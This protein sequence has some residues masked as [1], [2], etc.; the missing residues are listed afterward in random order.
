[1]DPE[2]V[3]AGPGLCPK[4]GMALEPMGPGLEEDSGELDAMTRRFGWCA[5]AAL[6]IV[7]LA[8]TLEQ[9]PWVRWLGFALSLPV[10]WW[11]GWPFFVRGRL[12]LETGHLNMFTLISLGVLMAWGSSVAALLVPG[13]FPGAM[14]HHGVVPVYF[15]SAVMIVTL[16]LLGQ[17]LELRAR[18]A[19][20]RAIRILLGLAPRTARIVREDGTEE[21]LPLDRVQPGD[22]LRVRPGEKTPVDGMVLEGGSHI[23]ESMV[24]GEPVPVAK[25]SGDAVIGGTV[26]GPGSFVMRAEKVGAET[27]LARI[28]GMVA[29]AQRSRAP[30]QKL[31]DVVAGFF[32]PSVLAVA[33]LS[34]L[35]WLCLGPEPRL[36][37]AVVNAV[38]VLIIAC[39]CALG[40][41]TPV[42]IMVATGRGALGG[43][44][45][46]Q[47]AALERLE[48]V[49]TLVLDKTGTLTEGKPELVALRA[50]PG[51]SETEVLRLAAGLEQASEHPVASAIV[52]GARARGL[53][54]S[55]PARFVPLVGQG[56]EGE[57]EGRTVTVGRSAGSGITV[58]VDG[59]VAGS[60]VVAD[61]VR[62]T[63]AEAIRALRASGLRIVMLTGDEESTARAVAVQLGIDEFHA[64]VL[65]AEK[66]GHI[67]R[68]QAEGHI[69]AMAGDGINDAPALA[70][71][72]VGIALGTGTDVAIE[73]AGITL[74]K[75]D[76]RGIVR[77]IRLSR[78]TMR[79][80]RQNLFLAFVYNA[81]GVPVAAGVLWPSFGI[82]LSP[83][84]AAAAMSLSSVSVIG[85]ALRLRGVRLDPPAFS[86]DPAPAAGA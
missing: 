61:P 6:P 27:L 25:S 67:A 10:V 30:V 43:V 77:A 4:C 31:A 39:P 36:A 35:L 24:T 62:E 80:I 79:N 59:R 86:R 23:D 19:T 49:D 53:A 1:M 14:R 34:F 70:R 28:A 82:L 11:G 12:S 46:R 54:L 74:V 63:S 64:R 16:V 85:N 38:A 84:I 33:G 9:V 18:S 76:L 45:I 17:V 44:L 26:N 78:A 57:V 8:M 32:V 71:A 68:L 72:D 7:V 83:M 5:A 51:F 55:R 40:L 66:L 48:R 41:A 47:A 75:G 65:P 73:S 42:S 52:R 69:V 81:V 22:T 50:E 60:L 3:Q 2:V 29:E 37:H 58:T 56:V 20:R 21:D 13:L 15:E